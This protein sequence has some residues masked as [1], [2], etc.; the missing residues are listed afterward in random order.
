MTKP[1][2]SIWRYVCLALLPASGL[3][4]ADVA[5]E[6]RG[7]Q[8]YMAQLEQR[9]KCPEAV[10]R[11]VQQALDAKDLPVHLQASQAARRQTKLVFYVEY[12][13]QMPKMNQQML[14]AQPEALQQMAGEMGMSAAQLKAALTSGV[15]AVAKPAQFMSR[16]SA[17][18]SLK[19]DLGPLCDAQCLDNLRWS[20]IM[21]L[22]GWKTACL[23]CSDDF[24]SLVVIDGRL[25]LDQRVG[26]WLRQA[27]VLSPELFPLKGEANATRARVSA[28]AHG[29]AALE[30]LSK[31]MEAVPFELVDRGDPSLRRVCTAPKPA[32]GQTDVLQRVQGMVCGTDRSAHLATA[33]RMQ[34]QL[35][36]GPTSCGASEAF[37]GC[38]Q[39]DNTIEITFDKTRYSFANVFGAK[40]M[41]VGPGDSPALSGMAVLF[42]EVGHWFG[43][44]HLGYKL[45]AIPD[46][47]QDTYLDNACASELNLLLM[48]NMSDEAHAQRFR[49]GGGYKRARQGTGRQ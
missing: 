13:K 28:Q 37:L 39:P 14:L 35:K 31:P 49:T 47:M 22:T 29:M 30:P 33:A 27:P 38:G 24:L 17:E 11:K 18:I 6:N 12:F 32:A 25:W 8:R 5:A 43:L 7:A 40:D 19:S 2:T 48:S 1:R 3:A 23:S 45:D 16:R 41:V 34:L 15:A 9:F 36:N 21:A 4:L 44:P 10:F 46:M 42:H 26:K 20:L